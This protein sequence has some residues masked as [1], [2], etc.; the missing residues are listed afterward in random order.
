[1]HRIYRGR[2]A[3]SPTGELHFGS[4]VAAVGS[5]LDAKANNGEW[6]VRIEDVDTTRC[7]EHFAISILKT[8]ESF[9]FEWDGPIVFQSQREKIYQDYFNYLKNHKFVYGCSCSRKELSKNPK[10]IDGAYLYLGKCR[11]GIEGQLSVRSWRIKVNSTSISFIDRI[12]GFQS[13]NLER[14]VGDYVIRR[15]DGLFAYQL[16]V[17]VDDI[18]QGISDVIRGADL[19]DSTPRQIWL[20]KCL[21]QKSFPRYVHLPLATNEH[22]EKLSKQTLAE[23]VTHYSQLTVLK[24]VMA[25]LGMPMDIGDCS[26]EEFW[27]AAITTWNIEKIPREQKIKII[28]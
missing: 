24:K 21:G 6:I 14:D 11:S 22:G 4:M 18:E 3:P 17:V 9:G 8:L 23:P 15:A 28:L 16:A 1:M 26:L 20:Y 13:Q 2:F 5:Y 25:F 27:K 19:L 10:G 7:Q 12:Q